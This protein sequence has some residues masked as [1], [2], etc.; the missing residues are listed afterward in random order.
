MD[1]YVLIAMMPTP[2]GIFHVSELHESIF[3]RSHLAH[4]PMRAF[5]RCFA[6]GDLES[7]LGHLPDSSLG[8]VIGII[9]CWQHLDTF[10]QSCR[11]V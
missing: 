6:F 7:Q 9:M 4:W 2:L 3:P 10:G 11:L 5:L 1:S 8:F